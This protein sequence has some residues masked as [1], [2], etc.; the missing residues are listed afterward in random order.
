ML[1]KESSVLYPD[2]VIELLDVEQLQKLNASIPGCDASPSSEPRGSVLGEASPRHLPQE[3]AT[4]YPVDPLIP[5]WSSVAPQNS[6]WNQLTFA[7]H[8]RNRA[9]G[10]INLLPI[11]HMYQNVLRAI[12]YVDWQQ[13]SGSDAKDYLTYLKFADIN[14]NESAIAYLD[15]L[16]PKLRRW[17]LRYEQML[18][19]HKVELIQLKDDLERNQ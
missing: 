8:V 11:P 5:S 16:E 15:W 6:R 2:R 18:N 9:N 17:L 1:R 4:L 7:K 10:L 14:G 12:A 13:E 3:W 19:C